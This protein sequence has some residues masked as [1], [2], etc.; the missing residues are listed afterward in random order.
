MAPN[1]CNKH[2]FGN[3]V[4]YIKRTRSCNKQQ[5]RGVLQYS[6]I[7]KLNSKQ[8]REW[9]EGIKALKWKFKYWGFNVTHVPSCRVRVYP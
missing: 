5:R 3:A 8:W 1:E 9:K 2:L 7:S 6:V 4:V